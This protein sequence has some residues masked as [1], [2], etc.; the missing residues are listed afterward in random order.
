MS[1]EEV[2]SFRFWEARPGFHPH[3][4]W[5]RFVDAVLYEV[6]FWTALPA[7]STA[8]K[9]RPYARSHRERVVRHFLLLLLVSR[10]RRR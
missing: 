4:Q 3:S 6:R 7:P 9:G 10:L 1:S 8:S 5:H 2:G